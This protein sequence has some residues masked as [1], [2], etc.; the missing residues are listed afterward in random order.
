VDLIGSLVRLRAPRPGDV[1]ALV[2]IRSDPAVARFTSS[3]YFAPT[4]LDHVRE[5]L[6]RRS[7]DDV[8]WIVE[9]R[10][11]RTPVGSSVLHHIDYRNRHCWFAIELA[12]TTWACSHGV[13][14]I[15]LTTRFA[16]RQMGLVKAYVRAVEGDERALRAYAQAGY[17]VE[18][19]LKRHRMLVDRLVTELWLAAYGDD[20]LY[21]PTP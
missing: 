18:A 9:R 16:F 4:R 1:E 6:R 15:R 8:R 17:T 12:P 11:G 13:E 5:S 21:A 10:E 2:A 14:A 19:E 3:P 20:P 7:P